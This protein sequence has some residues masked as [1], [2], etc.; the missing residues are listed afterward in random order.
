M[1]FSN[2]I[3]SAIRGFGAAQLVRGMIDGP[4]GQ[5][6]GELVPEGAPAAMMGW[7]AQV[8]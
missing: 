3:R 1:S 5:Q 4:V 6:C 8:P 7:Q 2:M